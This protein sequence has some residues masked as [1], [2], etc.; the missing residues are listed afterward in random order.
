[1]SILKRIRAAW[2][3]LWGRRVSRDTMPLNHHQIGCGVY[4]VMPKPCNCGA[5]KGVKP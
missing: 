3:I 1:M 5:A 2:L 4:N